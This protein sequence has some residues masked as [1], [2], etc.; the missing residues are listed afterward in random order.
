MSIET[1]VDWY[2]QDF[3]STAYIKIVQIVMLTLIFNAQND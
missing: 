3:Q 1:C 2:I